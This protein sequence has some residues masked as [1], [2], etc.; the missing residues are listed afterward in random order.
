MFGALTPQPD[1]G[2]LDQRRRLAEQA[3]AVGAL[4]AVDLRQRRAGAR[5]GS[6]EKP[7]VEGVDVEFVQ[8]HQPVEVLVD[9]LLGGGARAVDEGHHEERLAE[10]LTRRLVGH[11]LGDGEP[12]TGAGRA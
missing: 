8:A 1:D 12:G 6:L 4:P 10:H 2:F 5:R 3:A 7:Q 11:H 9:R